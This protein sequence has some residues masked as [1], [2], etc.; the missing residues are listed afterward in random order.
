L[1]TNDTPVIASLSEGQLRALIPR[2]GSSDT[3]SGGDQSRFCS[4]SNDG[5][6]VGRPPA[7]LKPQL[8]FIVLPSAPLTKPG[9]A[10]QYN[11]KKMF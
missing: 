3:G 9:Y 6:G 11:T 7:K 8:T 4:G 10:Q 1:V 5:G 2:S